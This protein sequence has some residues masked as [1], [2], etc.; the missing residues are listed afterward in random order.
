MATRAANP[1]CLARR[2]IGAQQLPKRKRPKQC[3]GQ[4]HRWRG[5]R[6]VT[7]KLRQKSPLSQ[8]VVDPPTDIP[9]R[10]HPRWPPRH[11]HQAIQA[12]HEQ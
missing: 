5:A 12:R 10:I 1:S 9:E 6:A 2:P 3:D 4:N 11:R 7:R 8:A